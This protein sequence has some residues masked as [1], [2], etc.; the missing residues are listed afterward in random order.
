MPLCSPLSAIAHSC[1]PLAAPAL[2]L[3]TGLSLADPAT[4]LV[5]LDFSS[6][7]GEVG[8]GRRQSPSMS[9]LNNMS[10]GG[11]RNGSFSPG[12]DSGLSSPMGF[13][14][15]GPMG[16]GG[17]GMGHLGMGGMGG[18]PMFS[19]LEH[20]M[21]MRQ[22]GA[23]GGGLSADAFMPDALGM[24]GL[25]GLGSMGMVGLS[26]IMPISK[27]RNQRM[28]GRCGAVGPR[29]VGLGAFDLKG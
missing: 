20:Q 5:M 23:P 8:G 27:V 10:M 1:V 6:E 9:A 17:L 18:M 16:M 22:Y 28:G 29:P 24:G 4:R 13:M 25:P 3:L 26:G 11:M 15:M 21:M 7:S 2:Q 14:G 19:P 12:M